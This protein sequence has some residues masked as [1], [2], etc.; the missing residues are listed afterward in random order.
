MTH[1]RDP[2][3]RRCPVSGRWV[4]IAPVRADRPLS[5]DHAQPHE[6]ERHESRPCPFCEGGEEHTPHEV[7]AVRR[8]VTA[9]DGPGW[10]VRVVP[11]KFPAVRP[12]GEPAFRV[13]G[14]L[15]L[16][17]SIP[18]FGEHELVIECPTHAVSPA[19]LTDAQTAAI[20][21][22]YRERLIALGRNPLLQYAT[23]FKNVGAE[24]GASVAH[25]HSQIVAT[26]VVP[27]AVRR[28][29][30]TTAEYRD[31]RGRCVFCDLLAEELAGGTRLV[32]VSD[33][34]AA[35]CPFAPRFGYEVWVLPRTHESR[36]EALTDAAAA[37][38][39]GL[40]KRVFRGIDAVLRRP[41]FNYWLHTAPFRSDPLPHYHWHIEIIPR[42]D[43]QAGYEW[44]SGCFINAVAPER[45]AAELRDA[46]K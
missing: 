15:D 33:G 28:E 29:L 32:A 4:V 14:E 23:V 18:G 2:E 19:E 34:F 17:D 36:Y 44:G 13:D 25:L 42:T 11:N 43:R 21:T 27:E 3:Y 40:L 39:A 38:L 24:A 10:S 31:R 30:E 1:S 45:A 9:P 37:D 6:R 46:V 20:L 41:A 26:P 5:L 8:P 22:A 12:I 35:V 16:F 7:Y